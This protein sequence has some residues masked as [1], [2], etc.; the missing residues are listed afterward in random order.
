MD[1][2]LI[3]GLELFAY[4]G[5]NPEEQEFGQLFVLDIEAE[6]PLEKAGE[7]DDLADTVSY[8]QIIKAAR[9]VFTAEKNALLERAA[10]R[11]CDALLAQ[12]PPIQSVKLT[13]RKPDA[14][15]RAKFDFVAIEIMRT[16]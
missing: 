13:L 16:R 10:R 3:Q 2:I 9:A 7:S 11:V 1:K 15:I 5:V 12:F 14:P 4:H 6:I 8:A